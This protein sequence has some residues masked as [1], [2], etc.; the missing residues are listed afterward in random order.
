MTGDAMVKQMLEQGI[1]SALLYYT[2]SAGERKLLG[3]VGGLAFTVNLAD[4]PPELPP[5][6]PLSFQVAAHLE[7][8]GANRAERRR[9]AK[10]LRKGG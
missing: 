7:A 4:V 1:G 8:P 2:N 3:E 10:L 9:N 5:G 6:L